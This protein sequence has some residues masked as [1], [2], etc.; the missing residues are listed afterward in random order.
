MSGSFLDR[1][2]RL[3][4]ENLTLPSNFILYLKGFYDSYR[5]ALELQ[6]ISSD[7]VDSLFHQFLDIVLEQIR[8]PF[9]F[10]PFHRKVRTPFDYYT[11]GIEIIRPLIDFSTSSVSGLEHLDTIEGQLSKGENVILLAN[12]QVEPD[13]QVISLLLEK[14]HPKL[15]EEMIFVAG[16]RVTTDPM[17]IPFSLGRNLLCIYSKKRIENPPEKK[18]EKQLHNQRTMKIMMQLLTE[19]GKCIYVAPSGGR[20][21]VNAQNLVEIAPFD[22]QSIEMFDLMAK[23]SGRPTHFYPLAMATYALFPPPKEVIDQLI[24]KRTVNFSPIRISFGEEIE[25]ERFPGC[26]DPN[27]KNRRQLRADYIMDKV[28]QMYKKISI[29]PEKTVLF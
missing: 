10:E 12:H 28:N 17:A 7:E 15:A 16:A 3:E 23:Q 26:K 20:D 27:K 24:E 11:W 18:L 29:H 22:P 2:D 25:M 21:R 4:A 5:H 19:G 8:N 14:S 6:K 1:L 9:A 13:P